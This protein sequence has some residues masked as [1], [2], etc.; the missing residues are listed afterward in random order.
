MPAFFR[1][2]SLAVPVVLLAIALLLCEREPVEGVSRL[3]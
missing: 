2:Y 3:N 1:A